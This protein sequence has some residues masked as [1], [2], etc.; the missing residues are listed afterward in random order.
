MT[1]FLTLFR[2]RV[3]RFACTFYLD[4]I[5]PVLLCSIQRN[6]S[7]SE[8]VEEF[9][10]VPLGQAYADGN[11]Q[12]RNGNYDRFGAYLPH[13]FGQL[14]CC[15]DGSAEMVVLA[16]RARQSFRYTAKRLEM[17]TK[18]IDRGFMLKA[19]LVQPWDP[20]AVNAK[21]RPYQ[22]CHW[23]RGRLYESPIVLASGSIL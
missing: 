3:F 23:S 17:R 11:S 7:V 12:L 1:H 4:T 14:Q 16:N 6:I 2:E 22:N 19:F 9:F 15:F 5:P 10:G 21:P 8:E 18:L 20:C 13:P